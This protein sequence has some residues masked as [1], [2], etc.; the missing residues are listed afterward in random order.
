MIRNAHPS[1]SAI[2]R[3]MHPSVYSPA[4]RHPQCPQQLHGPLSPIATPT[5]HGRGAVSIVTVTILDPASPRSI[6]RFVCGPFNARPIVARASPCLSIV[7]RP[8]LLAAGY[9]H[10]DAAEVLAGPSLEGGDWLS[11][12]GWSGEDAEA[13]AHNCVENGSLHVWWLCL[14]TKVSTQKRSGDVCGL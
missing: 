5:I 1:L 13:E 14:R 11:G 10:V 8:V 4:E 2:L 6:D 9:V 3:Y 12:W 7:I